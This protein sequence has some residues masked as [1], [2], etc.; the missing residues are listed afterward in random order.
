[1]NEI[2][3]LSFEENDSALCSGKGFATTV[4]EWCVGMMISFV[5]VST[6]LFSLQTGRDV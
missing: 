6:D 3:A 2:N 4:L 5:V 1:M